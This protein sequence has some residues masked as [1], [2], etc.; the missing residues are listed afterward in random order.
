MI[1]AAPSSNGY[2]IHGTRPDL[3][4]ISGWEAEIA[5]VVQ[6]DDLIFAPHSNI[7]L[8]NVKS[9]LAPFI[10]TNPPFLPVMTVH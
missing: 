1:A 5:S 8:A 3:P 4:P 7:N 10:C 6:H 9:G 2:H